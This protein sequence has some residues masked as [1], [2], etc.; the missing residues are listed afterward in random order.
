[1]LQKMETG[2]KKNRLASLGAH[3]S[4]RSQVLHDNKKV[5]IQAGKIGKILLKI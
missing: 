5:D 1:M 3:Q 2:A 4:Q